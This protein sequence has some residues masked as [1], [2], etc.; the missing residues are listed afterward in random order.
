MAINQ[1]NPIHKSSPRFDQ[2]LPLDKSTCA[3]SH[4]PYCAGL[5]PL[6]STLWPHCPAWDRLQLWHP[7]SSQPSNIGEI[8]VSETDLERILD[9]INVSWAKGTRDTYGAGLL[10]YHIF[11]DS[12]H[13]SEEDRSPASLI[14]IITFISSCAGSYAGR[15]LANYVFAVQAWHILH[16]LAWNMDD[17]QVKAALTGA[18][19]L[20]PLMSRCPKRAPV[21]VKLMEWIFKKLDLTNPLDAAVTG[22]FLMIFYLAACTGEFTLPSLNVFNPMQHVKP[23][24]ISKWWDQN[25][26]EVTVFRIPKTKCTS[27]REDVF[28]SCQDGITDPKATLDNHLWINDPPAEGPLFAYRHSRG[29]RPLTKKVFLERINAIAVLLGEQS[30]KGHGIC[31]RAT[32]EFLFRGVPFDIMKS[33]GHW[34]SDSFTLYLCQHA[35]IIAPYIQDLLILEEFTC[36]T[37]PRARYHWSKWVAPSPNAGE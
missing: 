32:L 4:K 28:W 33:L 13:I 27:D 31:I 37:M 20:A 2:L 21:T 11:C 22:C 9:V 36:Y 24:D 34:S 6:P 15:T 8:E 10:L 17:S 23:S 29:L 18:A 1:P 30:L 5:V 14:L 26:L 25:N 16:R 3:I 35:T 12:H 7:V 19:I